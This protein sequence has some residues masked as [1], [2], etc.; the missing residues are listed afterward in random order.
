VPP[1]PPVLPE[2]KMLEV[3]LFCAPDVPKIDDGVVPE[4]EPAFAFPLNSP[5]PPLGAPEPE[6]VLLG[7]GAE[8]KTP[9]ELGAEEVVLLPKPPKLHDEPPVVV[10]V[11]DPKPPPVPPVLPNR[12]GADVG[13]AL[14]DEDVG[15]G[16]PELLGFPLPKT[17]E[18]LF[19]APPNGFGVLLPLPVVPNKPPAPPP[20]LV[21]AAN[22]LDPPAGVLPN[23]PPPPPPPDVAV[24]PNRLPPPGVVVGAVENKL[25][26]CPPL[27]P[28][29][30]CWPKLNVFAI[31][32]KRVGA[33][34]ARSPVCFSSFST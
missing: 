1:V 21:G 23:S 2:L 34:I 18:G 12:L 6:V 16:V 27:E 10:G 11:F 17:L 22:G 15:G 24:F 32:P 30:L 25:L 5:L 4:L 14:L 33:M 28:C 9:P 26:L 7:V 3:L 8:P 13:G 20:L 29:W 19:P 31:S